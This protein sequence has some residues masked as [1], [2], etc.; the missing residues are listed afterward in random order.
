MKHITSRD[1]AVFKH[2]KALSGSTQ[3]RRRAGQSVLDGVHLVVAY[4]DAGHMPVQCLVSERHIRHPE[5][6]AVLDRVDPD[7]VIL[8]AD[9]LFGQLTTVVNGVDLMALVE[10]PEGKLPQTIDADCVILDGIQDA[11][12]V[13]SILRCAAAAGVRDVFMTPGCAFAWSAKT[14]RAAMGAHF[15]LNIVEHCAFES[16]HSRL[17]VPLLAT[18]SHAKQ[19]VFDVPLNAPV[20]W[21]FGNEGAGVSQEWL[22]AVTTPV[23]IP[24]PGGM[25]SLNVAAAAAICLFEAVRQRRA[26]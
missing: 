19:A 25:E 10:T 15:H 2:L 12:N 22:S 9:N 3:H 14:L 20:G 11:G 6:A 21:V 8:L 1:N 18:S 26:A 17:Q 7:T 23:A 13:G 16:V 5:V 4:L 24:Q